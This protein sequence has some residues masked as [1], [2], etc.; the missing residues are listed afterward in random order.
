M[1]VIFAY[2][3]LSVI[4]AAMQDAK[5]TNLIVRRAAIEWLMQDQVDLPRICDLAGV[6]VDYL[7][8]SLASHL[9]SAPS[10]S[11]AFAAAFDAFEGRIEKPPLVLGGWLLNTALSSSGDSTLAQAAQE[12]HW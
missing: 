5:G 1:N 7:R 9:S 8:R 3:F 6:E 10:P 4:E 2:L 11:L 12:R